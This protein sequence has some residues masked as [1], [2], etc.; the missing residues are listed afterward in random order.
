MSKI[1]IIPDVHLKFDIVHRILEKEYDNV[2]KIVYLG[3]F[4]D[5]FEK[6]QEMLTDFACR[7]LLDNILFDP[8]SIV[9]LGNHDAP[10]WFPNCPKWMKNFGFTQE[11]A[12]IYERYNMAAAMDKIKFFHIEDNFVFSHAGMHKDIFCDWQGNFD[13]AKI[14]TMCEEARICLQSQQNHVVTRPGSRLAIWDKVG[15][16]IWA[17]WEDEFEPIPGIHQILGHSCSVSE[18]YRTKMGKGSVNYCL[19]C[20]LEYYFI[21]ENGGISYFET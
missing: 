6:G 2:D 12:N 13:V 7:Y 5:S 21:L 19:D 3:D 10:V 4:F 20:Y 18:P 16:L 9:L 1:L 8:K 17:D 11:K 14:E 15:G